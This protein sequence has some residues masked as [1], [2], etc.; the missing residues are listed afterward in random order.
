MI[1]SLGISATSRQ[2]DVCPGRNPQGDLAPDF[3]Y[4][5]LDWFSSFYDV[6]SESCGYTFSNLQ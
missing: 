3:K 2:F 4:F 1:I 6:L 5:E